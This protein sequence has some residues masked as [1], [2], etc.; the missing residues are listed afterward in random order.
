MTFGGE[1]VLPGSS[2]GRYT[3]QV[4]S[5]NQVAGDFLLVYTSLTG[6]CP[7]SS[8]SCNVVPLNC[9]VPAVN[10]QIGSPQ[11]VTTP[12]TPASPWLQIDNYQFQANP[13]D[14]L[15]VRFAKYAS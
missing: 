4:Y 3:I 2:Q 1:Y 14:V 7:S 6:T 11:P 8:P 5:Q 9:G 13:G 12:P 10:Q 15:S